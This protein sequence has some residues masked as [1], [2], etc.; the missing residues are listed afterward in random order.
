VQT[1]REG[2]RALLRRPLAALPLTLEGVVFGVLIATGFL[3]AD[4]AVAP[5]SAAFPF[6]VYFDLKQAIAYSSGWVMLGV[7]IVASVLFRSALLAA[8]ARLSDRH[9]SFVVAYRNALWLSLRASLFLFPA[10]AMYFITIATSY[11]PFIWVAALLGVV[12]ALLFCRRGASLST[13]G[14]SGSGVVPEAASFLLYAALL[15]GV[16]AAISVLSEGSAGLAALLVAC[17][18][19]LHAT[20]WLGWRERAYDGVSSTEGRLVSLVYVV[21]VVGLLGVSLYD[22]NLRDFEIVPADRRGTL[23]LLGGADSST[24]TGALVDLE[25][26]A[27]GF[28]P[29]QARL[30]SYRADGGPYRAGDT[31]ADLD[32]VATRI[33]AQIEEIEEE[34]RLLLGHSQASL[35]LD[36]MTRS[37]VTLP[38]R[39]AVI[40]PAPQV[41]PQLDVPE[42]GETGE[43]RVGGDLA[44]SFSVLLDLVGMTPYDIDSPASP[45]NLDTLR[46]A[47]SERTRL[48]LWS[49]GDSVLLDTDWRRRGETNLVVLS[50]HVGATRNPRALEAAGL[51]LQGEDVDSDAASW[52]SVLVNVYRYAFEPWRP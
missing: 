52:R 18:G 40:S 27:L 15:I 3:P 43:G 11:A 28:R 37:G 50:D 47:G 26:G 4:A 41:P 14:A 6:D 7:T 42:P 5:A 30:L 2:M 31:H 35:I 48:A 9:G 24:K 33:G 51:W 25:P 45:T 21:L 13:G 16:G 34:P 49:L 10:A 36:R 44:R 12:P 22:R 19:P 38:E 29:E 8:T 20:V 32:R 23:L 17:L 1:L 46:V 39:S